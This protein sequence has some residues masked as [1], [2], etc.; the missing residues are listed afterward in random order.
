MA[1][2]RKIQGH[3]T[4]KKKEKAQSPNLSLIKLYCSVDDCDF[5]TRYQS[6]LMRHRR[7]RN[8]YTSDEDQIKAKEE[9]NR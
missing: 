1:E 4:P 7:R 5:H 6:N 9:A 8:H 3:L 2:H